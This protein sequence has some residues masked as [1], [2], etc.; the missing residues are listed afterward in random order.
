MRIG[1]VAMVLGWGMPA[2]ATDL[3]VPFTGERPNTLDL[4]LGVVPYGYGGALGARFGIPIVDNGF[5]DTINN[6]VYVTLGADI[7]T[8]SDP[9]VPGLAVGIPI[10]LQW[11]FYF[12]DE[13][14]AF[15][16]GGL[17]LYAGPAFWAGDARLVN[18]SWLITAVGGRYHLSSTMALQLRAGWP[19]TSVGVELAL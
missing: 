16:E 10:T 5:V 11:S 12:T 6:S 1:I 15:G 13:W 3:S 19:Y 18:G 8:Y 14:S 2:W 7:Y 4:H 9:D 17:N